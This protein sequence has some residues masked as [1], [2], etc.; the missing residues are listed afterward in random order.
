M[1]C[2]SHSVSG[3]ALHPVSQALRTI[4]AA[5]WYSNCLAITVKHRVLD[6]WINKQYT[7]HTSRLRENIR[8]IAD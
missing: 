4:L 3:N 7:N 5:L 6:I 2:G 1:V 8:I